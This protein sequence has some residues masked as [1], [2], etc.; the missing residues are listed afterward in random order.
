MAEPQCYCPSPEEEDDEW[1]GQLMVSD[2]M[3]IL[4]KPEDETETE[5][6]DSQQDILEIIEE[7]PLD[8]EDEFD[9]PASSTSNEF[10]LSNITFALGGAIQGSA[11]TLGNATDK[12]RQ[13]LIPSAAPSASPAKANNN[14]LNNSL[15]NLRR[16][17]SHN[18]KKNRKV[19]FGPFESRAVRL[20]Y[21]QEDL[22]EIVDDPAQFYELQNALRSLGAVTNTLV[23]QKLHWYI[24]NNKRERAR[25]A[26]LEEEALQQQQEQEPTTP[27]TESKVMNGDDLL[28]KAGLPPIAEEEE[29]PKS[30]REIFVP[31]S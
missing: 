14:P 23:Q 30:V 10:S 11:A 12:L 29:S 13:S 18:N 1:Q 16:S 24:K 2:S 20:Q 3:N 17:S 15:S 22:F 19:D 31:L 27:P 5:S 21:T 4:L 26:A 8:G 7:L 25:Q 6:D 9:T 28:V